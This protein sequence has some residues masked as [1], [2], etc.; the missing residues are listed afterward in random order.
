MNVE[1]VFTWSI[2]QLEIYKSKIEIF[3]ISDILTYKLIINTI[4]L[5]TNI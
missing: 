2:K 4:F 5:R 3:I 1:I